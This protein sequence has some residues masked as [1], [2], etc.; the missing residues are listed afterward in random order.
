MPGRMAIRMSMHTHMSNTPSVGGEILSELSL[1]A[2]PNIVQVRS[3]IVFFSGS[4]RVLRGVHYGS[5]SV[6]VSVPVRTASTR[7]F[8]LCAVHTYRI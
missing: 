6:G 7:A 4:D 2:H 8:R 3:E 5:S 1:E